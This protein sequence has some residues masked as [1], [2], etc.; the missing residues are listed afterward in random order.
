MDPSGRA[1]GGAV[2]KDAVLNPIHRRLISEPL[3]CSD[4]LQ[5]R[6]HVV[7]RMYGVYVDFTVLHTRRLGVHM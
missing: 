6:V 5:L 1:V 2:G 3:V 7:V 4:S